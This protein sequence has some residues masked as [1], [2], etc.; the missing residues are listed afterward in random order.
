MVF[1]NNLSKQLKAKLQAERQHNSVQC[2]QADAEGQAHSLMKR[3]EVKPED[4]LHC[5]KTHLK[6]QSFHKQHNLCQLVVCP[7]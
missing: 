6:K 5:K 4:K 2:V 1:L 7:T 3:K